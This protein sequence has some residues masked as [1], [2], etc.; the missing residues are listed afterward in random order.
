MK[1][2]EG[3]KKFNE[4][5]LKTLNTM[6][7]SESIKGSFSIWKNEIIKVQNIFD[8]GDNLSNIF[9]SS[10][11]ILSKRAQS[12]LSGG[13]ANWER[14]VLWY[15]NLVSWNTNIFFL[16]ANK[17]IVPKVITDS[18]TVIIQNNRTNTE[19]DIFG[20]SIP[21]KYLDTKKDIDSKV[22]SNL[23]EENTG[24]CNLSII[25][26]K[27][28]WNDNSQIPM[29]WDMIYKAN[30]S[31]NQFVNIGT[32]GYSPRSFKKFN[33]SFVTVPTGKKVIKA[34]SLATLRVKNLSGG[35]YWGRES[36][37]G[38]ALSLKEFFM[39]NYEESFGSN[40]QNH[41]NV[42]INKEIINKFINLDF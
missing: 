7:D 1:S 24:E 13:G 37:N 11:P 27:T 9:S 18:T 38:V 12:S 10:S 22:I 14:L 30:F 34:N 8:L 25:Q 20:F 6:F 21:F 19:S 5:K 26:C 3:L 42:K 15:L 40:I 33:Y 29:L 4:Y 2:I 17:N 41:I 39:K 35:N 23:I 32:Y 16:K 31:D 28:N 36:A